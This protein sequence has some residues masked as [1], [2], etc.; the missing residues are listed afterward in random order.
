MS[1]DVRRYDY[2]VVGAGSAGAIV[3]ARLSE[4]EGATVLLVE[5][6]PDY[7]DPAALPDELRYGHATAAYVTTHGHLWN[8]VG[9]ATSVQAPTAFPRGRVTGGTSAVNGQLF[10]R[11]LRADFDGWAAAGNDLW[12]F[13][14]LLPRMRRLERDLDFH[15]EWHGSDGPIA[16]RRYRP[17]EWLAPQAAFFR[18]CLDA[19]HADCPDANRPDA[20]GIGPVPFNNVGGLRASTAVTYLARARGRPNLTIRADTTVCRLRIARGRAAGVELAGPG[21]VEVVEA[22]ECI[23]CGGSIGSP[24]VLLLSGI[25]PEEAL[26]AAGV[27]VQ[28]ALPGVGRNLHDHQVADLLWHGGPAC[29]VPPPASPRVQVA[30][31]YTA[32]GSATPDDMQITPRD[33]PAHLVPSAT[34]RGVVAL[35]PCLEH[36]ESRGELRLLSADPRVQPEIELRFLEVPADL[37]RMRDGVRRCLELAEHPELRALLGQRVTPAAADVLD[38]RAIDAWLMRAVRTSH[39]SGGT[40]KMGTDTD[41]MAVVDQRCRVRGVEGLRVVDASIFPDVVRA[42]TNASIMAVAE[43]AVDLIRASSTSSS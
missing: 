37:E 10:L 12:S 34:E 3:A 36:A 18:A 6:G 27:P 31:R 2:V 13:D 41:P 33:H 9:R 42:N 14:Q 4:D 20:T 28:V 11:G 25:G 5:A 38:D 30:L 22:G 24:H 39:H 7:P 15:D 1:P 16:V 23:V 40:C 29:P 43:R 8:F 17:D 21:G 35:V 32:A 19:G 26:R